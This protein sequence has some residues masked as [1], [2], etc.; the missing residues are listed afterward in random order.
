MNIVGVF[1]Q[2]VYFFKN[3][4]YAPD[5]LKIDGIVSPHNFYVVGQ[6][7]PIDVDSKF[8]DWTATTV[9]S[10]CTMSVTSGSSGKTR[11]VLTCTGNT[12][13]QGE[14]VIS[15]DS[16]NQSFTIIADFSAPVIVPSSEIDYKAQVKNY[17]IRKPVY[18]VS[19]S[20]TSGF[21]ASV[22]ITGKTVRIVFPENGTEGDAI[23]TFIFSTT[24]YPRVEQT[25]V[26]TQHPQ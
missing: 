3:S 9:P 20:S 14:L 22:A 13:E 18:L 1:T 6:Q 26:I 8:S 15:N 23:Y 10:F 4:C 16:Q 2:N 25:V 21:D 19:K 7:R 5:T 17:F 11:T 12:S 24:S